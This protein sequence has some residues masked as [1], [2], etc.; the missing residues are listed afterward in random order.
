MDTPAVPDSK[1]TILLAGP[2]NDEVFRQMQAPFLADSRFSIS[3]IATQWE[4]FAQNLAQM[5]PA[6]VVLQADLAPGAD[7]LLQRLSEMQ[8]WHGVAVL[9][10]PQGLRELRPTYEKSSVVRATYIAPVNW[11][12]IAQAG[13][14]AVMNERARLAAAAPLQQ[15]YFSRTTTVIQGTRVVAFLSATGGTGRSTIAESLAYELKFRRSAN[16]LLLSFDLP[17]AAVSHLRLRY[18]PNAMEFFARPGDGFAAAIQSREGLDVIVAP[19][20]SLDYQRAADHST[21]N[22]SDPSSI[23]SLAM[24]AWTRNYAAVLLDLP[25][26]E[27]PWSLQGLM[28]ANTAVIVSRCTLADMTAA[29]HVMVL[30]LERLISEH[31]IPREAIYLVLNQVG[32]NSPIS[33]REFHDEL[34]NGYGWAPPVAAVIPYLPAISQ[35]QDNQIP[36]ITRVEGLAKGTRNLAEALYPGSAQVHENGNGHNG[37]ARLRLPIIHFK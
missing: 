27:Q 14:A 31:R 21:S 2:G 16:T 28:A 5:R 13:F 1:V 15:A 18:A 4:I 29:R 33:P 25:A 19:E 24:T 23:Y 8:V 10:I 20:N 17:P 6:L 35:A 22:K 11:G 34:A 3:S 9:V 32:E 37:K 12:E 30:L 26:G 7:A 36:A